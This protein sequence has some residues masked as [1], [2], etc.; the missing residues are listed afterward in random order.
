MA[1]SIAEEVAAEEIAAVAAEVLATEAVPDVTPEVMVFA[2][3]GEVTSATMDTDR[4]CFLC[5]T[6]E[7][8][9]VEESR[10]M[11]PRGALLVGF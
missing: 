3:D 7:G 5:E 8:K 11:D 10:D 1:N 9:F 4:P 6:W 2:G